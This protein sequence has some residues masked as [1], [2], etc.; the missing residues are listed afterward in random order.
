MRTLLE[1]TDELRAF[2]SFQLAEVDAHP[3]PATSD[4]P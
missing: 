4:A 2:Q 1:E 3:K